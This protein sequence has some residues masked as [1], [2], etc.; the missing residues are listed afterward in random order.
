MEEIQN[1]IR[2]GFAATVRLDKEGNLRFKEGS[3]F[4]GQRLDQ[5]AGFIKKLAQEQGMTHEAFVALGREE[6]RQ[7]KGLSKTNQ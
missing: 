3:K 2:K 4:A 1:R 6:L 5:Q 7:R